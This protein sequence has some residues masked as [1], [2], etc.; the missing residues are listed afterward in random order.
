MAAYWKAVA[1][2]LG[3]AVFDIIFVAVLSLAPFLLGRL[4]I[5]LKQSDQWEEY[6]SFLFNGQ[7]SFFAMGSLATLLLLCFRKKLPD[8]ATIWIGA[9]SVCCMLFLITLVGYDPTLQGGQ[10]FIGRWA[11]YLYVFVLAVRI[12]ADAMKSVGAGDA[13]QAGSDA[14]ARSQRQLSERMGSGQ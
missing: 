10:S 6:W 4:A 12:L 3:T 11:L 5:V 8:M 9:F 2:Q 7:L 13:L 1:R 14:A